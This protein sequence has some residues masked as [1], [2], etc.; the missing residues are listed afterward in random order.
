[1]WLALFSIGQY[2]EVFQSLKIYVGYWGR[3]MSLRGRA[4]SFPP[5]MYNSLIL[6]SLSSQNFSP[7]T[8]SPER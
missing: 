5:H 6:A 2:F 8:P 1:M 7:I 4:V 3:E